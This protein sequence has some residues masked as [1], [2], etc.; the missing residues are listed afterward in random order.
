MTNPQH[1]PDVPEALV[2]PNSIGVEWIDIDEAE[3]EP[4]KPS[5]AL[6]LWL[7]R[8][9]GKPKPPTEPPANGPT[10]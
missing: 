2:G 9:Y 10:G 1:E 6:R 7:E 8:K 4:G 5:A 3:S